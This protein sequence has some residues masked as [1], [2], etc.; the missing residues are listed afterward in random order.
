MLTLFM[1]LQALFNYFSC[2]AVAIA[3]VTGGSNAALV[4][5]LMIAAHMVSFMQQQ[6]ALGWTDLVMT[7]CTKTPSCTPH[8][9]DA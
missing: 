1:V 4:T 7:C 9:K 2:S 8:S 3:T 5:F 6:H